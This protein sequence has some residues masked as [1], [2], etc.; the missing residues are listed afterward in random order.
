MQ[1]D[2]AMRFLSMI[3]SSETWR[4]GPPPQAL[5]EGVGK[6]AEDAAK[7]GVMVDMGGLL[8]S[9]AGARITLSGGG[10]VAV[11]D[12]PFSEAKELVGGYAI[13]NVTSKQDAIAWATRLIDLHKQHWKG[14]EGE[15]EIRQLMDAPPRT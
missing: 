8:P 14:W 3:K 5:M 1:K 15:I 4:A 9:S 12:G 13:F 6:L 7:A 11:I 2:M 10:K